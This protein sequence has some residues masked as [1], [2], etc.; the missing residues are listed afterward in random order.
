MIDN[1]GIFSDRAG[2]LFE[3]RVDHLVVGEHEMQDVRSGGGFARVGE[4]NGAETF[5]RLG[6]FERPV[7]HR[8]LAADRAQP[9]DECRAHQARAE[10]GM[11]HKSPS[12]K[13]IGVLRGFGTPVTTTFGAGVG[14]GV[15]VSRGFAGGV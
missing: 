3:D 4:R 14:F 9:F 12:S 11:F 10:P 6:L 2:E 13:T 8:N 1:D 15:K 5:E 7:V